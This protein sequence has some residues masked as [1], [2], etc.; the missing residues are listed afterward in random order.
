[1]CAPV[2]PEVLTKYTVEPG[3]VL[4]HQEN[5]KRKKIRKKK[6]K[7]MKKQNMRLV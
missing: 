2:L 6:M 7:K 4:G 1:M 5:Q 3:T